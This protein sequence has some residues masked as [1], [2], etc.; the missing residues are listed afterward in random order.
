MLFR[1]ITFPSLPEVIVPLVLVAWAPSCWLTLCQNR[2]GSDIWNP[3]LSVTSQ[4][5]FPCTLFSWTT[6]A[7][8]EHL[9]PRRCLGLK[10]Q[11]SVS[12]GGMQSSTGF[13]AQLSVGI[14]SVT[15]AKS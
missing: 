2:K 1:F 8:E 10:H 4:P 3:S 6:G 13:S 9:S 5:P 12:L 11:L 14:S 15:T 7:K